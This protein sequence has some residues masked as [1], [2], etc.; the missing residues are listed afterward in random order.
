M[1]NMSPI[2]NEALEYANGWFQQSYGFIIIFV[3]AAVI[4]LAIMWIRNA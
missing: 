2:V 4:G 3:V 1:I